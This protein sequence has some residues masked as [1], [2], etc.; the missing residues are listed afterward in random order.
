MFFESADGLFSGVAH[1][2]VRGGKMILHVICAEKNLQ[3]RGGLVVQGLKFGFE[4]FGSEFLV[5]V[6]ICFD[7]FIG[8]P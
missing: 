5:S 3:S 8:G 7:P 6:L 2:A 4:T 1:M